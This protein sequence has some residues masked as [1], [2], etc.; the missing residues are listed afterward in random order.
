MNP[1]II[2]TETGYL[3][4]LRS[5]NYTQEGAKVFKTIDLTGVF[6][7]KNFL[8][9]Y[10]HN[11]QLLSQHEIVENLTRER[12]RA[13]NVEGIEDCRLFD[14]NGRPWFSCTTFDTNP[15]SNLQISLC[16]LAESGVD[17]TIQVEKLIPLKGPD[18]TRC[19]K[20]WL[21]FMKDGVVHLVYS[22]DPFVIYR[23]NLQTGE[24]E[25]VLHSEQTLDFSRFRGSAAPIA[26]DDGYLMLVHEVAFLHDYFRCYLHRFV[27]LDK[28]FVV[29]KLSTPFTFLHQG[30]EF[31]ISMTMD[32]S[33]KELILPIGFEDREAFLCFIELDSVRSL[34]KPLPNLP[35]S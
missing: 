1:S 25:T 22:S 35:P 15:H 6:R 10:D 3:L 17:K 33:G 2:K 34:L 27:Y 28:N 8:I 4:I 21:P 30:V 24:C 5:V 14:F 11:F 18:L 23:P 19:E 16:E 31:C 13:F 7:T 26:F 29:Q 9:S 20:N 32:H 12:I